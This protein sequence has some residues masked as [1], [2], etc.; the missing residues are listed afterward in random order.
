MKFRVIAFALT[1]L[2]GCSSMRWDPAGHH[3]SI[4]SASSQDAKISQVYIRE[5]RKGITISGEL[6]PRHITQE[7]PSGH[8]TVT[9]VAPDGVTM[10][11]ENAPY[12]RMGKIFKKPQ[13]Y[14]FS[15]TIPI[16]PPQGSVIRLRFK[17]DP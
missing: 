14:S 12:Y 5:A 11:E 3:V 13:R 16:M 2:A 17:G 6:S 9:L 8:V 7:I 10:I 1:L 4:D 15:A